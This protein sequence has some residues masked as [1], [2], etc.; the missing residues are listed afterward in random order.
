RVE[1]LAFY[2]KQAKEYGDPVL[3]LAC[4]TGRITLP[5][6]QKG[7]RVVGIDLSDSMLAVAKEK[8]AAQNLEVK[9][10]RGDVREF[11]LQQKFPLIIFPFATIGVLL[12]TADL[13]ACL[14]CVKRHLKKG[15]RFIF[16]A[17]N[18]R[19]DI[20]N[21]N[22][23]DRFPHSQFPAPS[24]DGVITITESNSYNSATQVSRVTLFFK[25]PGQTNETLDEISIRM[26]YPQELEALLKYNGFRVDAKFGNF[27]ETPF[28]ST[29]NRQII[30]CTRE[31][32]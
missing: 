18:P 22:P 30:I 9:W 31:Q 28:K 24:G 23:Q 14:A 19:M 10:V 7:Y 32:V 11:E 20:L 17:L 6:A 4:G 16:D 8:A 2:L 3:E 12:K 29:S 15:G 1:D 27:D 25:F 13:E 21:R 5:L 26:Y